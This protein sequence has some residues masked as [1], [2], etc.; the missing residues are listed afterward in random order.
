M[1]HYKRH[2]CSELLSDTLIEWGFR[3]NEY[4]K[5][6]ENKIINGK[7]CNIIWNVNDLKILHV[8]PNVVNDIIKN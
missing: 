6:V 5:C 3:L 2:F 4:D 8:E 1:G 7:Q